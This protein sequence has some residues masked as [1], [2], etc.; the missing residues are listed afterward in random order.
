MKAQPV[1]CT[2]QTSQSFTERAAACGQLGGH[3]YFSP[4][5]RQEEGCGEKPVSV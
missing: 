5:G 2:E 4:L 3:N 1:A